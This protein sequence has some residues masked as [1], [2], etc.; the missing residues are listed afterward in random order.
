MK[1]QMEQ[2]KET[3]KKTSNQKWKALE[4]IKKSR[5]THLKENNRLKEQKLKKLITQVTKVL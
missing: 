2:W 1:T 5:K 4:S 3:K